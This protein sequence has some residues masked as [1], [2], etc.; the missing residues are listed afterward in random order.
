LD[1]DAGTSHIIVRATGSNCFYPSGGQT[2]YD[3]TFQGLNPNFVGDDIIFNNVTIEQKAT[4]R[5]GTKT[6]QNLT[7]ADAKVYTFENGSNQVILGALNSNAPDCSGMTEFRGPATGTAT[8][9]KASGTVHIPNVL[10]EN[11]RATGGA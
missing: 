3:V 8:I 5:S 1:F 10:M 7:L 11:M 4:F 2:Y 9:T 6:Y